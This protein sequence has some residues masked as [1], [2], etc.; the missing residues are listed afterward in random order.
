MK[1]FGNLTIND[2]N[3]S[4]IWD[5][6]E[7]DIFA[8]WNAAAK[9]DDFDDSPQHYIDIIKTAFDI[10]EVKIDKPEIIAKYEARGMHVGIL[11]VYDKEQKWAI[12]KHPI[13]RVTDL[14]YENIRH[15]SAA[16][17]LEVIDRNFGGGWDSLNQSV[18]DVIL[19][20][21]DISTTTVPKDRLH[22]PGG[23]CEI[24]L[25]DGYELLEIEKG[26]W[27]EAIFAKVKPQATKL[28][29]TLGQSEQEENDDDDDSDVEVKDDYY[30][31]DDD[32]D[33]D[34]DSLI[35]ESYRTTFDEDPEELSL[36]D[37]EISDEDY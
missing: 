18:K 9:D 34:D 1:E 4:N 22:R 17:L 37:A 20:G 11:P 19:E 33:I 29:V 12:K 31:N 21:F 5:I 3:K 7:S 16:K 8:M 35:D 10:E 25:N 27:V 23:L 30:K 36:D 6:N 28:R 24:K 2:I 15:I 26:T 13:N 14:T 32:D